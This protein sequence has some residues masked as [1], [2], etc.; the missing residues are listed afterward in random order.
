MAGAPDGRA[1]ARPVGVAVDA[2]EEIAR[3]VAFVNGCRDD[4][5]GINSKITLVR[6]FIM[7]Q[8][9][10]ADLLD[11]MCWLHMSRAITLQSAALLRVIRWQRPRG[12]R[13]GGQEDPAAIAACDAEH[14]GLF[15]ASALDSCANVNEMAGI[16]RQYILTFKTVDII[17]VLRYINWRG[18][19]Q[20]DATVLLSP[21]P[22]VKVVDWRRPAEENA[23]IPGWRRIWRSWENDFGH[24]EPRFP[25]GA[26]T[27]VSARDMRGRPFK[28]AFL[29]SA[30]ASHPNPMMPKPTDVLLGPVWKLPKPQMCLT[31]D[32]GSM[33]PRQPDSIN[34]MH[35][36][37]QYREWVEASL[38]TQAAQAAQAAA[39]EDA[40]ADADAPAAAP[41]VAE[42]AAPSN[43]E[44][45]RNAAAE[46]RSRKNVG[47]APSRVAPRGAGTRPIID[48]QQ[49]MRRTIDD[50][51]RELRPMNTNRVLT[52]GS[53][54]NLIYTKLKEVFN[55]LLDAAKQADAWIVVDRTNGQGS[56]TAEVFL[57]L[58]LERGAQRPTIVAI[59]S[60][61]RL[62]EGRDG[63]RAHSVLRQL[64][65][66]FHDE[67]NVNQSPNGTERELP[68]DFMYSLDEFDR[69]DGFADCPDEELP[70]AVL[71]EHMRRD[72]DG[73]CEPNRKWMY[74][75]QDSLF[76]NATHYIIKNNDSDEFDIES[77][78]S[79]GFVYAH[80]DACT[81]KRLRANI[82]KAKPIVMLHNSGSV[83]TAFSWLQRV[84][85]H[86]FPAPQPD[87]LRGPLKF[88][89]ANLSK[90]S[91]T[92]HLG[93]PDVIMMKGLAD[94]APQLFR[95]HIVSVDILTETEE[96]M[97]QLIT[98]CVLSDGSSVPELG[99]GN[100]ET[101]VV[102][103]A[104]RLHMTL[105][106]NARVMWFKSV[107]AQLLVWALALV[108][109]T[110]A[111]TIGSFGVGYN[112]EGA[113]L[114]RMIQLDEGTTFLITYYLG[115]AAL[116][117]PIASAL[118]TT[119]AAKML[120]RDKWSVCY[121][122]ATQL[123]AEIYKFRMMSLEYE[124]RPPAV[125][126]GE[127]P[128]P[129]PTDKE[130]KRLARVLFVHRVSSF[131]S[132]AVR[133]LSQGS[134]IKRWRP[135]VTPAIRHE[136]RIEQE[137]KPTLRQWA[138]MKQHAEQYF[139]GTTWTFPTTD[140]LNWMSGLQSFVQQRV[141]RAEM[142]SAIEDLI[143]RKKLS[144]R[145]K[146]WGTAQTTVV[147]R[148][149]AARLGLP[150]RMLDSN[151]DALR[152][153][154]RDVVAELCK[155]QQQQMM[156]L[157]ESEPVPG[158]GLPGLVTK[159]RGAKPS[160]PP[161]PLV[162]VLEE[163][164]YTDAAHAMRTY[165]MEL[166]GV[167]YSKMTLQERK[168]S[169]KNKQQ[170]S[171]VAKDVE[172]DYLAGSLGVESYV[173]FR[174]R[175]LIENY[176]KMAV[177]LS[178]RLVLYETMIFVVN[179]FGAM[180][181]VMA[182]DEWV[183]LTVAVVAVLTNVIEFTQLRNQV[184]SVNLAVRDLQK[185]I[186]WWD[187]LSDMLRRT[188]EAK[189]RIIDVTERVVIQVVEEH[190]TA[191]SRT[192]LSVEKELQLQVTREEGGEN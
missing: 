76:A 175:P 5:D 109:T 120:W 154:Q 187:S 87:A 75:Y 123:V 130:K 139:Y 145:G 107:F 14:P 100:A 31:T 142:R 69:P 192:Q 115:Q 57:E 133:E 102:Y 17:D 8:K 46:K 113:V 74:F 125:A 19:M 174:V 53:I 172:D 10:R 43:A 106:Q 183:T 119:L 161:K 178:N 6:S 170:E 144:L 110:I 122:A 111:I 55:A 73:T 166:Q 156:M 70:F 64:C 184:V 56:A 4:L 81:Y 98:S 108:T 36:L 99:L 32:A 117:L 181:A 79:L 146:P 51:Q 83:V 47:A 135:T 39:A 114:M 26:S 97:M 143:G 116:L 85:A 9:G 140:F 153:L 121:M 186:V 13:N 91:W 88:L 40:G 147:R 41:V 45:R 11:L 105:A 160:K 168:E 59:D 164:A 1:A 72:H 169:K 21:N 60:L 61:E 63:N 137:N 95:K 62:G 22:K 66:A 128:P 176:E 157:E 162:S 50:W 7:A 150:L 48:V 104:W 131:Y 33:H 177:S 30:D 149:L 77:L 179:A 173:V 44:R 24:D 136:Y 151:T 165:L 152:Q 92:E 185:L 3:L 158:P 155:E 89:I 86:N 124:Y 159:G 2:P 16:V 67:D 28:L 35:N 58:A 20:V 94:R 101:N 96:Q 167:K 182:F 68:I 29:G 37:P 141:L 12:P 148:T 42:V 189:A 188:D 112:P 90:A 84:L 23:K 65:K 38:A 49:V 103:N 82:Q 78:A 54:N 191:A 180:L 25:T 127:D 129:P 132:C 18:F 71:R 34:M 118:A 126:E 134:G 93:M 163:E 171:I 190:T 80:G 138:V 52:D 15:V 27:Y